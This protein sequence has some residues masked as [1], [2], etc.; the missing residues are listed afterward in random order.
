VRAVPARSGGNRIQAGCDAQQCS[1]ALLCCTTLTAEREDMYAD[2]DD[3]DL[4]DEAYQRKQK[5]KEDAQRASM[6]QKVRACLG[7]FV[8]VV[9]T[10]MCI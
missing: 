10:C 9:C 6:L 4:D 5:A 1:C 7:M 3:E 2:M 8:R